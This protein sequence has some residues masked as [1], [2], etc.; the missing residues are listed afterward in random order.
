MGKRGLFFELRKKFQGMLFR[1]FYE[2]SSKVA[3]YAEF[4]KEESHKKRNYVGSYY[5]EVEDK[6]LAAIPKLGHMHVKC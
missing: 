3:K 6:A 5:R 1:D 2:F 4:L